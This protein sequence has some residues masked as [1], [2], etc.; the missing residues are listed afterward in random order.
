VKIYATEFFLTRLN[1]LGREKREYKDIRTD[2]CK[3]ITHCESTSNF[4]AQS[5]LISDHQ[6]DEELLLL[7]TRAPNSTKKAGKSNG[8]RII[9]F[10]DTEGK[11][12]YLLSIY[13]KSGKHGLSQPDGRLWNMILDS[14][15]L[16]LEEGFQPMQC[17]PDLVEMMAMAE[18]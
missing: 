13:P 1:R 11:S 3:V 15:E 7:K 16:C 10:A 18:A 12:L 2:I 17:N 6:I 9:S 5:D 8:Y 4:L 14:Y